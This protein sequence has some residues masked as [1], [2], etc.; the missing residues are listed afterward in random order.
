MRVLELRYAPTDPSS[1]GRSG[2]PIGAPLPLVQSRRGGAPILIVEDDQSILE[3]VVSILTLEGY[4]VTSAA[5]GRDALI[6]LDGGLP[7][8][9]LLDM[10][11][12]VMDGWEFARAVRARGLIVPIVVMT[13]AESAQGWAK[14]IGADDY[15]TKP[16]EFPELLQAI[17]RH[18]LPPLH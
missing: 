6:A 15:V 2:P 17:E 11:M 14:E 12:P 10:R 5:N 1:G 16:F 13:A 9:I 7:S 8:L 18:R 4:P 3:M